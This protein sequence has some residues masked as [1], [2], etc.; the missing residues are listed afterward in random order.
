MESSLYEFDDKLKE[1]DEKINFF[2]HRLR[3]LYESMS[4]AVGL[5][6]II[7]DSDNNPVDY[8]YISVN[9]SYAKFIG[10]PIGDIIGKTA[11]EVMQD[12]DRHW[13]E[14]LGRVAIDGVSKK[15]DYYEEK[16]DKYLQFNVYS[17]KK[18]YFAL[19][20]T[21]ITE[22]K[23]REKELTAK[24]EELAAIYEELAASEEELRANY[25]QMEELKE[26][27][28]RAN[29][30]KSLFLANMSHEIRTPLTGII[31]MADLLRLTDLNEYQREYVKIIM[32]SGS[33]LLDIINN[34]LDMT[35]I[36][37]GKF[38]LDNSEFNL[39][40][41]I[42]NIIKPYC[43]K[44]L[45]KDIDVMFYYQPLIDEIVKGDRVRLNQIIVNLMGNAFKYTEKGYIL[46]K[47]K[48]IE[49]SDLKI[50]LQ[51][52][53][54]DT[55]I[56][57]KEEMKNKL[58]KVF[59]QGDSSYTKK[60]GGTGLGL[61]ICREIATMMQGEIW[62][63]SEEGAGSTFY[64][65]AVFNRKLE[66]DN[67][68]EG[69]GQSSREITYKTR[70]KN[71]LVV[72]D[73]EINLKLVSAYLSNKG[74]N[75]RTATN[76]KEAVDEFKRNDVDLI[77]MGIQMPEM[78]G[79]EATKI[80]REI[81]KVTGK[82]TIIIAMTAYAMEGDKEICLVAGMDDYVAKPIDT[83]LLYKKIEKYI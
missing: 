75:F 31:G 14:D 77:L 80:I 18:K 51:F 12:L 41:N 5:H 15:F 10:L 13:I 61:A 67:R 70:E 8:R 53:V 68:R 38:Q 34:I 42:E 74:Y 73:N 11:L 66:T 4:E 35:K 32:E 69:P 50:K 47:V 49:S 26:E 1:K 27:A 6:E 21:D 52:S 58:F 76:G 82:H 46:V 28:E 60:Y 9:S 78:N 56:G 20:F 16:Q 81:D 45:Q 65:T 63:E 17:P 7:T 83:D 59:S 2:E 22:L 62:Y 64:F 3:L 29:K 79:I 23:L 37:S 25:Q 24:Y 43:I 30:I 40:E 39:K 54:Q 33:H 55:G 48:E 19:L 72:E 36:E 44:G 57:I 71:I